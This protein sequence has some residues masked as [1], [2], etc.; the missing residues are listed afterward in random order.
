M[1]N[2][3]KRKQQIEDSEGIVAFAIIGLIVSIIAAVIQNLI[4]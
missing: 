1:E 4:L 3:G 2:Q